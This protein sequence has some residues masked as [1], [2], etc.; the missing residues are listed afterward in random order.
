M[1]RRALPRP[2][3]PTAP[4]GPATIV[5]NRGEAGQPLR[6]RPPLLRVF[7]TGMDQEH[8]RPGAAHLRVQ[9]RAVGGKAMD[10]R[11]RSVGYGRRDSS[12][13]EFGHPLSLRFRDRPKPARDRLPERLGHDGDAHRRRT[14]ARSDAGSVPRPPVRLA[15]S[16]GQT[17]V[18][19]RPVRSRLV[20]S[21]PERSQ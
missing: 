11:A 4:K 16:S 19:E 8:G 10:A 21:S 14:A 12:E 13:V 6:D 5:G 18:T 2:I 7:T 9:R 3:V 20:R 17:E 15:F 1:L